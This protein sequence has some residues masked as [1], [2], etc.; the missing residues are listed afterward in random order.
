[1]IEGTAAETTKNPAETTENRGE[2]VL[3]V[4]GSQR[5]AVQ[6]PTEE[7]AQKPTD[8]ASDTA[9][10]VAAV[11]DTVAVAAVAPRARG[12]AT[13]WNPSDASMVA[14]VKSALHTSTAP[15][16]FDAA[17]RS[18]NASSISFNAASSPGAAPACTCA[19]SRARGSL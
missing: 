1:M 6:K 17:R 12:V 3:A 15:A 11:D 19:V 13:R 2:S 10:T 7:A 18:A 4:P 8:G 14:Q 5:D 16:A 9:D